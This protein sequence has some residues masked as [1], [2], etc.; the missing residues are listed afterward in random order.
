MKSKIIVLILAIISSL[1]SFYLAF[2]LYNLPDNIFIS[3]E[4]NW[5]FIKTYLILGILL[6]I[7]GI[8]KIV[9]KG[10]ASNLIALIIVF[11]CYAGNDFKLLSLLHNPNT[12]SNIIE[13]YNFYFT[14]W[15]NILLSL[16]II[17]LDLS[18]NICPCCCS[19]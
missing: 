5:I 8:V 9:S 19:L 15:L 13:D 2:D 3:A 12:F 16:L 4:R 7:F 10:I 17:G 11:L 1:V 18:D 14:S 6:L